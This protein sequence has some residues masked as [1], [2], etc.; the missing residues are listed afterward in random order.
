MKVRALPRGKEGPGKIANIL[1][2]ILLA[3]YVGVVMVIV[4]VGFLS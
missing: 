1:E 2:A 4:A 3:V